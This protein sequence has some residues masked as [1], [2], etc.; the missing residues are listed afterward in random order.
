MAPTLE[1]KHLATRIRRKSS[2]VNAVDDVSLTIAPGETLGLVG[3]SGCGKTMTAMSIMKLLPPGGE[4][5]SGQI[6][7]DGRDIVPLGDREMCEIRG[8]DV[9]VIFQDALTALNPTM[10]I[11]AQIT[12]TVRLH[13][14]L[15][16]RQAR[17]RAVEVLDLVGVP[18]PSERLGDY[19]HTLSGG[20]RQRAMIAMA[21]ANR[22]KLLIADEPTTALDVTI[23]KQ[24]LGLLDDLKTELQTAVLLIT[25]DLGVIAGYADRV[26]VMYAGRVVEEAT[27]HQLFDS[28]HHR[29]TEA[30][31]EAIPRVD[32]S[33]GAG[34]NSIPGLPPDLSSPPGG[35]RFSPRCRFASTLC[36]ETDPPT[37]TL[38]GGASFACH[39]P[40]NMSPHPAVGAVER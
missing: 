33:E 36:F 29:Y 2:L 39:H 34:F 10:T 21:I 20:L 9:A 22:P 6:L 31:L 27:V 24:I 4:I 17:D 19:A 7:I 13:Q 25:H 40:A 12:E 8:R 14:G 28:V 15:T 16:A 26:A 3:E 11:G 1:I 18:R 30:L 35:C 32:R 38:D 5:V 37:I 23:Q